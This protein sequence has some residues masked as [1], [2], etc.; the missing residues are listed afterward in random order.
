MSGNGESTS[1]RR[2]D[3]AE[4]ARECAAA[5]P[6]AS[7]SSASAACD[8]SDVD[9]HASAGAVSGGDGMPRG[10]SG[11]DSGG[12]ITA[13]GTASS[14]P[15]LRSEAHVG[16]FVTK[17]SD[18]NSEDDKGGAGVVLAAPAAIDFVSVAWLVVATSAAGD[19]H[20]PSK[21]SADS[22]GRR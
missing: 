1:F 10:G 13:G 17:G 15:W 12:A 14:A 11:G 16:A 22:V 4:C 9:A 19:A 3:T 5:A 6:S 21:M 20:A 2:I 8:D 18:T 7:A